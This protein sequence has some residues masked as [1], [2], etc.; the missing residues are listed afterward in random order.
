MSFFGEIRQLGYVVRDIEAA[1][2]HW[3]TVMGIG[4]FFHFEKIPVGDFK[5]RGETT[6]ADVS[7]ALANCGELQI[8]LIQPLDDHPTPYKDF[9]GQ[10]LEGMQHVAFWSETFQDDLERA[11]NAGF[12]V[13]LSGWAV[14]EDG[15]FVYFDDSTSP[16]PGTMVE[17][18][19]L[20][21]A[22]KEVFAMVKQVSC[23]WN[24]TDPVRRMDA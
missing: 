10:G 1:M 12:E 2:H 23:D 3:R 8:E 5:Y 11:Q 6:D 24:G 18:S 16:T 15:L 9:L 19:A 17:L 13:I 21:G 14:Q 4:P 20:T 7:I 22:K